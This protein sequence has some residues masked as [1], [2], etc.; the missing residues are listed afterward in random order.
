MVQID[1]FDSCDPLSIIEHLMLLVIVVAGFHERVEHNVTV[2]VHNR[3]PS[4][5]LAFVR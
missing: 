1:W 4:K 5:A 3:N 2:K